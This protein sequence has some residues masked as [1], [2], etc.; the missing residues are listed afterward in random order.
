VLLKRG[1]SGTIKELLMSAEYIRSQGNAQIILC[2]R[3]IR[4]YEDSTRNTFDLSAIPIIKGLSHLPIIAD[5]S[6]ALGKRDLVPPMALAA[7]AA[8]ADGLM[9]EVHP[10]PAEALCDGPQAMYP[11]KFAELMK[12]CKKVAEAIGREMCAFKGSK[13]IQVT[14]Q[15]RDSGL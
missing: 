6:H 7:V 14:G 1:L 2:E 9:I 4:T 12:V 11:A 8:G 15:Y 3:G 10:N 13:N 5:P